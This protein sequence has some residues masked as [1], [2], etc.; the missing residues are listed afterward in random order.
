MVPRLQTSPGLLSGLYP[1]ST[2]IDLIL[3]FGPFFK[4]LA[5]RVVPHYHAEPGNVVMKLIDPNEDVFWKRQTH[6]QPDDRIF[7]VWF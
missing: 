7:R 3:I 4:R 2:Q 1:D 6:A 5:G